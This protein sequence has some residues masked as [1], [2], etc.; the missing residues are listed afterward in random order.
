MQSLW[1]T[2]RSS[3]LQQSRCLD[4]LEIEDFYE[5][6]EAGPYTCIRCTRGTDNDDDLCDFC[7]EE[8]RKD[9]ERRMDVV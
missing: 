1:D 7:R 6:E 8:S 5:E 2:L 9:M 4:M 3:W